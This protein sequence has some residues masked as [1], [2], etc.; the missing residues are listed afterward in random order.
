[1]KEKRVAIVTG[2]ARGIGAAISRRLLR[3]GYLV[4]MADINEKGVKELS[5]KLKI[6]CIAVDDVVKWQNKTNIQF[7]WAV[8]ILRE[9]TQGVGQRACHISQATHL[10]KRGSFRSEIKDS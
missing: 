1:M 8:N 3:D 4:A 10:Y 7:C 9:R 6:E 2:A 5:D